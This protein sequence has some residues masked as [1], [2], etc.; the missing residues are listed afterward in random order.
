MNFKEA[1]LEMFNSK[2]MRCYGTPWRFEEGFQYQ[3]SNGDWHD[4]ATITGWN[5]DW[6]YNNPEL[7]FFQAVELLK[8]GKTVRALK[9]VDNHYVLDNG[10]IKIKYD[11]Q[12]ELYNCVMLPDAKYVEVK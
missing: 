1:I 6:T 11:N 7:D 8:Q 10:I 5:Q 9:A 3:S 4:C 12:H 2:E